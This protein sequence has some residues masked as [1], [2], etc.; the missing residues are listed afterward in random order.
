MGNVS[1]INDGNTIHDIIA[2]TGRGLIRAT[3]ESTSTSTAFVASADGVTEL[4]NGLTIVLKNTVVASAS[5]C[6]L[7]LNTLDAKRIWLSQSNSYC[8]THFAKNQTYIFIY[9][10]TNARW[11]LQQGRDTDANTWRGIKV[12]GTAILGTSPLSGPINFVAGTN[13]TLT[14]TALDDQ[15][16]VN[17]SASDNTKVSKSGDTMTGNLTVNAE[18]KPQNDLHF[19]DCGSTTQETDWPNNA[20]EPGITWKENGY[21]DKFEIRPHFKGFDDANFLGINAATGAAGTDPDVTNIAKLSPS[22]DLTLYPDV[23]EGSYGHKNYIVRLGESTF[24]SYKEAALQISSP[25]AENNIGFFA[26]T[27]GPFGA[28]LDFGAYDASRDQFNTVTMETNNGTPSVIVSSREAWIKALGLGGSSFTFNNWHNIFLYRK[29][30]SYVYI[31]VPGF[32][33]KGK[34][35]NTEY[36]ASGTITCSSII[37]G[38][39]TTGGNLTASK[40]V[41]RSWGS[42]FYFTFTSSFGSS[43]GAAVFNGTVTI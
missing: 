16:D 33:A 38:S 27:S 10:A 42:E 20:V 34:T 14:S 1:K 12:N 21:G 24:G 2:K 13:V 39:G 8:T 28:M 19:Q 3:M 6:T 29:D 43:A 22:G 7:K 18:V 11:E 35:D 31:Y 5:G 26:A 9:D 15:Y 30:T 41:A 25:S 37:L 4:Y 32:Y 17:I 40:V 36:T 23:D